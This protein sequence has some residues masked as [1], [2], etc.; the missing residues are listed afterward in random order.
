MPAGSAPGEFIEKGSLRRMRCMRLKN[1]T[2]MEHITR[3]FYRYV[4]NAFKFSEKCEQIC[5]MCEKCIHM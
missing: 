2:F 5:R 4:K 3:K 1:Y